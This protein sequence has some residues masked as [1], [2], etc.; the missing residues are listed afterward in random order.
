MMSEIG[1]FQDKR[2]YLSAEQMED[3]L[4]SSHMLDDV[5]LIPSD[6]INEKGEKSE[7]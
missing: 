4:W 2:Q 1:Y 3:G 7:L 6:L 5:F